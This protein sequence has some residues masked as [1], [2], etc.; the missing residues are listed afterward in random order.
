GSMGSQIALEVADQTISERTVSVPMAALDGEGWLVVHP[1]AAGGGPKGTVVLGKRVLE[2]GSYEDL[3]LGI[4]VVTTD[5]RTLY[6]MLHYDDPTDGSFT[7]PESGDPPVT[8]DGSPVVKPFSVELSE[9]PDPSL[10]VTDQETDG[11]TVRVPSLAIDRTGWLVIHPEAEGGGPKGGVTLATRQL[12]PGLYADRVLSLSSAIS[13]DQTLYAMLHYDDPMDGSFTFPENG[14]PP[15][16]AG[17][18]PLV[19]PFDVTVKSRM[20]TVEAVNTTFKPARLSVSPGT[21]GKWVNENPFG[22]DVTSAQFHEKADSWDISAQ[23][24]ADGGTA[25]HTFQEPGVYEYYCTIHGKGTMCGAVLVGDVSP[26]ADLPCKGGGGG[27]G[28][29]GGFY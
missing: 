27:G 26:D 14:D 15:V 24:S 8:K 3:S 29:G 18:S 1:E 10:A 19:K 12:A 23:L 6:A 11:S 7:F 2:S 20:A 22:H 5:G 28:G 16:T 21:T 4:D 17:G 25:T 9:P 13:S